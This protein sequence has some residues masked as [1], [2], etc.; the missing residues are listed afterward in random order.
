LDSGQ[1]AF[2]VMETALTAADGAGKEQNLKIAHR[3]GALPNRKP[4]WWSTR[5]YGLPMDFAQHEPQ[6]VVQTGRLLTAPSDRPEETR[7]A[8]GIPDLDKLKA[9]DAALLLEEKKVP[10]TRLLELE[11]SLRNE[12]ARHT[13][14]H[15]R[16]TTILIRAFQTFDHERR[17][18]LPLDAFRRALECFQVEITPAEGRAL[19]RKF[20]QDKDRRMPYEVFTRALF[21]SKSR[22]LAWTRTHNMDTRGKNG[23]PSGS[24]F[25]QAATV[26]QRAADRMFDAKIQPLTAGP[27]HCVTGVYPPTRWATDTW[28]SQGVIHPVVRAR[29]PPDAELELEHVYGYNGVSEYDVLEGKQFL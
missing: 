14:Y 12:V 25:V 6:P 19:F 24:P 18:T 29:Q 7:R 8:P 22:L 26:E 17:G 16:K 5:E 13:P 10:P 1:L 2:F 15:E 21:T 4:P 11:Q 9:R 23:L 27:G 28:E 20:G 3:S